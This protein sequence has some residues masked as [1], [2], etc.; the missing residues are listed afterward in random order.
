LTPP[1][2]GRA[3]TVAPATEPRSPAWPGGEV[4]DVSAPGVPRRKTRG[5]FP[6]DIR[7]S[8]WHRRLAVGTALGLAA[9]GVL[10]MAAELGLTLFPDLDGS[11]ARS[12]MHA[13]LVLHG[14]LGYAGAVVL[15]TLLGRHVPA[16]LGS[17]R[18]RR[19]GVASLVLTAGL[20]VTALALYYV[21]SD[22]VRGVSSAVHQVLGVVAIAAVSIH[23]LR[24]ERPSRRARGRAGSG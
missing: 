5:R 24:R 11:A 16:G 23:V 13:L 14:V 9:S 15:G 22:G 1:Q 17:G 12:R 19:T 4:L 6:A 21:G 2:P 3:A 20:V 8:P 7:L 18:R 10:W